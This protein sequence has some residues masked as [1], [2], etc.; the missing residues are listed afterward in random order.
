MVAI[1]SKE[2]IKEEPQRTKKD[3]LKFHVWPPCSIVD[4]DTS[5]VSIP[6]STLMLE[7][8]VYL[9]Y[10]VLECP[11]KMESEAECIMNEFIDV[12]MSNEYACGSDS[13][14]EVTQHQ[15]NGMHLHN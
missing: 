15:G 11:L 1:S 5:G 14:V 7:L 4:C 3:L 12:D 13:P 8:K 9:K 6:L 10:F 2:T